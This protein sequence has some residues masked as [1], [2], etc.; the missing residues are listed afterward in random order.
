MSLYER[1]EMLIR[2]SCVERQPEQVSG[3]SGQARLGVR[4]ESGGRRSPDVLSPCHS[5]ERQ[6]LRE[7][8][9]RLQTDLTALASASWLAALAFQDPTGLVPS[10]PNPRC[11]FQSLT[12]R[13]DPFPHVER[14]VD[15]CQ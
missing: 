4:K 7:D 12:F 13:L 2:N 11:G 1:S 15:L 14:P 6:G 10:S 8:S 5:E 3:S 9:T